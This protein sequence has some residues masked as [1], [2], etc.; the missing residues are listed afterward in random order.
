MRG[1]IVRKVLYFFLVCAAIGFVAS[2]VISFLPAFEMLG[3]GFL[4]N[5][6]ERNFQQAYISLSPE[7]KQRLP[8]QNF[9]NMFTENHFVNYK[10]LKWI[11]T[12][13]SP[14][15]NSGTLLGE[16]TIADGRKIP[17]EL[18]FL[19]LKTQTFSGDSWFIDDF[20]IGQDVLKRQQQS[21]H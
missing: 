6:K 14:D 18:I 9:Q 7:C 4:M 1:K 2:T 20:Y 21:G 13:V 17:I 12:V 10:D 19:K 16:V 3:T 11:K 15:K 8:F 5:I